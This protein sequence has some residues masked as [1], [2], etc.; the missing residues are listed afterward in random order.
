MEKY[1]SYSALK[2]YEIRF[3]NISNENEERKFFDTE[4][5]ISN[6]LKENIT[7]CIHSSIMIRERKELNVEYFL[8]L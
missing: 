8:N 3:I 7:K 5:G 2:K 4:I 1:C 6:W